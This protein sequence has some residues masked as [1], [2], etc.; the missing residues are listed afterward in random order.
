MLDDA[1]RRWVVVRLVGSSLSV[2]NGRMSGVWMAWA[3]RLLACATNCEP[4]IL[5]MISPSTIV[6]LRVRPISCVA[7]RLNGICSD[8]RLHPPGAF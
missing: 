6:V 3:C 5:F 2:R 4:S 1:S 8:S 7:Y